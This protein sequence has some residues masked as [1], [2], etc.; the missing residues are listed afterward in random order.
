MKK[1]KYK[2]GVI[3]PIGIFILSMSISLSSCES[4]TN[5][6]N[7]ER[8][9]SNT[10]GVEET[11]SN[12]PITGN[13]DAATS[14]IQSTD[15][16]AGNMDLS[17][18][19]YGEISYNG[20]KVIFTNSAD[21]ERYSELLDYRKQCLNNLNEIDN[22]SRCFRRVANEMDDIYS[23]MQAYESISN[24]DL[25]WEIRKLYGEITNI[26]AVS[27]ISSELDNAASYAKKAEWEADDIRN[28]NDVDDLNECSSYMKKCAS[29]CDDASSDLNNLIQRIDNELQQIENRQ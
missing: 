1:S 18:K 3:L 11:T 4:K 16:T 6:N 29:C 21:Q 13:D 15:A 19:H 17:T 23:D 24:S 28:A 22:L 26:S 14:S 10:A 12:T 25:S 2:Q 5:N 7:Q 27:E 8:G 20:H 9:N